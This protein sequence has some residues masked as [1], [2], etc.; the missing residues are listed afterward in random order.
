MRNISTYLEVKGVKKQ[1]YQKS[2][3]GGGVVLG[4]VITGS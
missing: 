1:R 2:N 3:N 4:A